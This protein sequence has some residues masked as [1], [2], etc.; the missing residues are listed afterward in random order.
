M[1][2]SKQGAE[3]SRNRT[4]RRR[5]AALARKERGRAQVS[6]PGF[7]RAT[8]LGTLAA[9]AAIF[10]Y[11]RTTQ[12]GPDA[13][14]TVANVA[15]CTGNQSAGITSTADF[16][17]AVV[18]VL[19]VNTLNQDIAPAAGVSGIYF[20]SDDAITI[21]SDTGNFEIVTQ[22]SDT[23]GIYAYSEVS[24]NVSITHNGNI[25]TEGNFSYGI[26]AYAADGAVTVVHTGN[27]RNNASYSGAIDARSD[28][29]N[30]TVEQTGTIITGA[31]GFGISAESY[32]PG[33]VTVEQT[34][35]ITTENAAAIRAFSNGGNVDVTQ[36][37][38]VTSSN[39][40]AINAGSDGTG[41]VAV[42][43][44]GN[45]STDGVL[46]A[47]I[48]AVSYGSGPVTV[49]QSGNITTQGTGSFGIFARSYG[50]SPITINKTGG[51][52]AS[53]D[54]ADGVRVYANGGA[55]TV[56]LSGGTVQGGGDDAA[57]V[58]ISNIGGTS[59]EL[60]IAASGTLWALSGIA[61]T[62]ND[63][64]DEVNNAGTVTGNVTLGAGTNAFN[65]LAGGQF[66]SG[67]T[68]D[69]GAGNLLNNAGTLSPGGSAAVQTTALTGNINQTASGVFEVDVNG[70]AATADRVNVSGSANLAGTV[71]AQ[72]QDPTFGT[73]SN[74]IL[75]AAGGVTDNGL[76]L[77]SS[78]LLEASLSFPNATDVVLTTTVIGFAPPGVTLNQNQ[79]SLA[80]NLN[81]ILGSG[82]GTVGPLLLALLN[83]VQSVPAYLN[84]LDQL[85]PEGYLNTESASLF[86]A[87]EFNNNL[88]SC[89]KAGP[90]FTAISQGQCMWV[91]Y[92]GRWLDR[93]STRQNIGY[94][95]DTHGISGGGQ[96]AVAPNWFVGLAAAYEDSDLDTDTNA[97]ADT[98]RYMLGGV[99][100]YQ[101]GPVLMALAGS[102]GTGEV[103]MTRQISFGG[104]NAT[105]RSSYDV[106]HVGAT[107]HAAYLLDRS[108]WYAKPFVDIN[109]THID[110][111]SVTETGGGAA[112]LNLS[113][114]DETYF[115]VTPALELGTT[116]DRGDGRAI[117]PY[118][119]AGVTI[120]GDTDQSL[121]AR[122]VGAPAAA[123]GFT[124]TSEF[125]DVFADIEAGVTLFHGDQH[126]VSAGYEGRFSDD[127]E[128]HGFFVKGTRTF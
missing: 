15:T 83:D 9:S 90:G 126:T 71:Q 19:N 100:K 62:S 45:I 44:I 102:I 81:A 121:T 35:S 34:G 85:I 64:D 26:Y 125:D 89:P 104:F 36:T 74:V 48:Y 97:S 57:G 30:V 105:A 25:R 21:N 110:R 5:A 31:T 69:L 113:G 79:T 96:V 47:G 4:A 128:V 14:G 106:D 112:N 6:A 22:G 56:N 3:V 80:N 98:D 27:I 60:N 76:G 29:G 43:Q 91:R 111:D 52:T 2:P 51:L 39:F 17:P 24:G 32:G 88:L 119:R 84:A 53:G 103:D 99:I 16:N 72:V 118:V 67:A 37:G 101:S 55:V 124:S 86:A 46:A 1:G 116:I 68:V 61:V 65:N 70:V 122:F 33:T 107:F 20:R 63:G 41:N 12:A 115:S 66:N 8:T 13:C 82:G 77:V 75:S 59:N 28:N 50:A 127:T 49:T 18:N 54:D 108:S 42:T 11:G 10:G 40:T 23:Y 7:L 38:D 92:D 117:R 87:E 109:V 123:G 120:Y 114:S 94:D 58:Y 95:E 93:D 73:Q 78:P